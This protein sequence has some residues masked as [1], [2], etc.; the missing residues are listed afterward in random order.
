MEVSEYSDCFQSGADVLQL[1]V[2]DTGTMSVTKFNY[3]GMLL[4]NWSALLL[5]KGYNTNPMAIV[6]LY[7]KKDSN[8]L[9]DT[10]PAGICC[11]RANEGRL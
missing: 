4:D 9:A 10:L 5:T 11:P 7:F 1:T 3:P 2:L 8:L 6:L